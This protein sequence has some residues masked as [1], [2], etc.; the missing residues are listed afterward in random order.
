VPLAFQFSNVLVVPAVNKIEVAPV[1]LYELVIFPNVLLPLIVMVPAP[2]WSKVIPEKEVP[3][4]ENGFADALVKLI[5]PVPVTVVP[6]ALEEKPPVPAI[7]IVLDPIAKVFVPVPFKTKREVE[8][9]V[10]RLN[11]F[12]FNVPVFINTVL[13]EALL[14]VKASKKRAIFDAPSS[15]K[16]YVIDLPAVVI[17]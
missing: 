6:V 8:P 3:P 10:I 7:V 13:P 12:V 15:C 11:P 4:P 16:A 17:S 1:A 5:V 14:E 2:P 9:V